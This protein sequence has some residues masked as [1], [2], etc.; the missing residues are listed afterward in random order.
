MAIQAFQSVDGAGLARVDF[1]LTSN[2]GELVINELNTM[3]GLPGIIRLSKDVGRVGLP[4]D[5]LLKHSSSLPL[6]ATARVS[7][8]DQALVSPR[9]RKPFSRSD[10]PFFTIHFNLIVCHFRRDSDP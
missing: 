4:F 9:E 2:G 5:R 3:P 7:N 1:F 8:K 10:F 6:N